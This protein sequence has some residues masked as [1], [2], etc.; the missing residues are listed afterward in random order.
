MELY[1]LLS[2]N[3]SAIVSQWFDAIVETYPPDTS[4]FLKGQQNPFHNPV[5]AVIY[6]GME[7]LFEELLR[8]AWS[9]NLSLHLDNIVRIRAIQDFTPSQ[10]IGF[11]LHLKKIIRETFINEIAERRLSDELLIFENKVDDISLLAFDNYMKCREKIYQLKVNELQGW[12]FRR[13]QKADE[14][15]KQE[16]VHKDIH[17]ET[18]E[19]ERKEVSR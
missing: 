13:L 11:I 5:G 14:V 4:R 19:F 2:E 8:A 18:I 16:C 9:E 10:A 6:Q 1:N 15:Y 12:T 3:K 17:N 7:H